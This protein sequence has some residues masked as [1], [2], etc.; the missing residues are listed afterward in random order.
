MPRELTGIGFI[1]W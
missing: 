1:Q